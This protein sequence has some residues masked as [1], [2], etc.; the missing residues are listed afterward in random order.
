MTLRNVVAAGVAINAAVVVGLMTGWWRRQQVDAT[1]VR[2][3]AA[4]R[5]TIAHAQP[6]LGA[7]R[8]HA[9]ERGRPPQS[10]AALVPR[11]LR[12]L[13]VPGPGTTEPWQYWTGSAVRWKPG[14]GPWALGIHL[15]SGFC[16]YAPGSGG[17]YFVYH[18]LGGYPPLG[19]Q[20]VLE[21]IEGWG[22]YHTDPSETVETTSRHP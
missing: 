16:P 8:R 18:P 17:D 9:A 4:L 3:R 19:Y 12:E 2:R 11:Y 1:W 21:R 5:T 7:L 6:I 14:L 22:Y 10:L 15:D 13:P 20:G